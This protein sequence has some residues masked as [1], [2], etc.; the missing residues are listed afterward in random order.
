[1]HCPIIDWLIDRFVLIDGINYQKFSHCDESEYNG[2]VH[3]VITILSFYRCCIISS[4]VYFLSSFSCVSQVVTVQRELCSC[5]CD[6]FTFQILFVLWL[7]R[8][9]SSSFRLQL[10]DSFIKRLCFDSGTLNSAD[11][12]IHIS[13]LSFLGAY[14]Q[15]VRN[16]SSDG[17]KKSLT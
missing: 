17:C 6:F 12:P 4:P 2:F 3:L 16:E 10:L 8:H 15:G 5:W 13:Q 11:S 7:Q 1:M 14:T 9:R